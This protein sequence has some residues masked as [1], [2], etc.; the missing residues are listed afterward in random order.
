MG[1]QGGDNDLLTPDGMVFGAAPACMAESHHG[2]E[3]GGVERGLESMS[4]RGVRS[5]VPSANTRFM[6]YPSHG[7][8]SVVT[9]TSERHR[10]AGVCRRRE[11]GR[12]ASRRGRM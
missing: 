1:V 12:H 3:T 2:D 4:I 10:R 9:A 8:P 5:T 7:L 6:A 11:L